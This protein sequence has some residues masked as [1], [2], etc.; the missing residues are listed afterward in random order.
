ML[1]GTCLSPGFKNCHQDLASA[2]KAAPLSAKRPQ[3][4]FQLRPC[5]ARGW[6]GL[7]PEPGASTPHTPLG[8]AGTGSGTCSRGDITGRRPR[9]RGGLQGSEG[10]ALH[11]DRCF[12]ASYP[13]ARERGRPEA[14]LMPP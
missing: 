7:Q 5:C 8:M 6:L 1:K 13:S 9:L 14:R 11:V 3:R 2:F 4:A 10:A 12:P